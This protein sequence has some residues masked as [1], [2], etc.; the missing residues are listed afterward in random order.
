MSAFDAKLISVLT[1]RLSYNVQYETDSRLTS[2]RLD[3]L[4]KVTLIYDF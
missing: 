4:S 3:T 2:R 1:A